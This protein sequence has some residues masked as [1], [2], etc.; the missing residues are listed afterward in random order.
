MFPNDI[1]RL[2]FMY[3]L[4]FYCIYKCDRD[5]NLQT[6]VI[7]LSLTEIH[8]RRAELFTALTRT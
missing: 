2:T 8:P 5:F 6:V 3:S 4:N 1:K 7:F